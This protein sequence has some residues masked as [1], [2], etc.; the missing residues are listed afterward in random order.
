[1]TVG[2]SISAFAFRGARAR[3]STV[4]ERLTYSAGIAILMLL[5]AAWIVSAERD[6][7][8]Y[9]RDQT[10]W[11][12]LGLADVFAVWLLGFGAFVLGP[13]VVAATVA[14]ERRA[15]TLDQLR[16]TPLSPLQLAAGMFVGAPARLYLLC[17]GPLAIHVAAGLFGVISFDTL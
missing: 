2:A 1:M 5:L 16:T 8:P 11:S 15:G 9:V 13:A 6:V 17:A 14:G 3:R 10:P 12:V 7:P 4:V